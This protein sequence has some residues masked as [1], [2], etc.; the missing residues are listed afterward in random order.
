[1]ERLKWAPPGH[2]DYDPNYYVPDYT[3]RYYRLRD[4]AP[5]YQYIQSMATNSSLK[6]HAV[7]YY[8]PGVEIIPE[9]DL[10][11]A[12]VLALSPGESSP[13]VPWLSEDTLRNFWFLDEA[14]RRARSGRD[15]FR[16]DGLLYTNNSIF[17]VV[18]SYNRHRSDTYGTMVVRG[19]IVC[20]DL[21]VLMIDAS[22]TANT[23][24]RMYYDKRVDAFLNVEDPT[25]VEFGRLIFRYEQPETQE[26]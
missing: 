5:I 25:Q 15:P 2:E 11:G 19:S 7:N 16:F 1:M 20:A 14:E 26:G 10:G 23:G 3:P 6:E 17:G 21:G 8:S 9:D 18:R 22:D 12:A 24:F 4:G 13:L